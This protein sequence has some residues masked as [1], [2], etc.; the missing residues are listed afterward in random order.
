[1]ATLLEQAR[2]WVEEHLKLTITVGI[3]E[4][5]ER[6]TDIPESYEQARAALKYKMILGDNR[7]IHYAEV[8]GEDRGM[9]SIF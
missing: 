1:M 8:S 5:A 3:G 6:Y 4:K 7:I 9:H 2:Q